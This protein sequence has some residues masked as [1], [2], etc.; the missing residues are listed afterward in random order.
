MSGMQL[1]SLTEFSSNTASTTITERLSDGLQLGSN[2]TVPVAWEKRDASILRIKLS[3]PSP[4]PSLNQLAELISVQDLV[5]SELSNWQAIS[6]DDVVVDIDL[7]SRRLKALWLQLSYDCTWDIGQLALSR[8]NRLVVRRLRTY[9]E[10]RQPL[11][12]ARSFSVGIG[13]DVQLGDGI[14]AFDGSLPALDLSVRLL[15]DSSIKVSEVAALLSLEALPDALADIRIL[16]LVLDLQATSKEASLQLT[17]G[18]P[19]RARLGTADFEVRQIALA[20]AR[21]SGITSGSISGT[22][23]LAGV[24]IELGAAAA[25]G[26]G[27]TFSGQL[28]DTASPPQLSRLVADLLPGT[29]LPPEIPDVTM[30]E[31]RV[32]FSPSTGAVDISAKA[33]SSFK[34]GQLALDVNQ[35]DFSF[36][37]TNRAT[38]ITC[39]LDF[40]GSGQISDELK[41]DSF[42]LKFDYDGAANTFKLLG[43]VSAVLF[44]QGMALSASLSVENGTRKL[45]VK[46]G[47]APPLRLGSA[48]KVGSAAAGVE[49]DNAEFKISMQAQS[50]TTWSLSADGSLYAA[51]VIRVEK[52][53]VTILRGDESGLIFTAPK[54]SEVEIPF[55]DAT[56]P[57]MFLGLSSIKLLHASGGW[58]LDTRVTCGLRGLPLR[59]DRV[60]G[61]TVKADLSVTSGSLQ[62]TLKDPFSPISFQIPKAGDRELGRI[63]FKLAA[64]T[65][66]LSKT[67]SLTLELQ[68]GL[69]KRLDFLLG[70]DANDPSQPIIQEFFATVADTGTADPPLPGEPWVRFQIGIDTNGFTGTLLSSPIQKIKLD[71]PKDPRDPNKTISQFTVN[72]DQYGELTLVVPTLS[73]RLNSGSFA[74]S[75]SVEIS[76]PLQL[77]TSQL[78]KLLTHAGLTKLADSLP[79]AIPLTELNLLDSDGKLNTNAIATFLKGIIDPVPQS[80]LDSL[81]K[82]REL[83]ARLPERF[84]SFLYFRLPNRLDYDIA[85][86]PS[87]TVKFKLQTA[88][89]SPLRLL[90]PTLGPGGIPMLVGIELRSLSFGPVLGGALLLLQADVSLDVF[91]IITLAVAASGVTEGIQGLPPTETLV[92][93]IVARE[94][95]A[96]ICPEFPVPV[97]LF[98]D[99][100]SFTY[101][102]IEGAE[103]KT[104]WKCP[105]P[106]LDLGEVVKVIDSLVKYFTKKEYYLD[107]EH[108]PEKLNLTFTSGPHYFALPSYLGGKMLGDRSKVWKFDAYRTL[109]KLLN[110]IKRPSISDI[111]ESMP[112]DL[113]LGDSSLNLGPLGFGVEWAAASLRETLGENRDPHLQFA[114]NTAMSLAPWQ[115]EDLPRLAD[116]EGVILALKGQ[117]GIQYLAG[118]AGE[119]ALCQYQIDTRRP[120]FH[121]RFRVTGDLIGG[122]LSA[123]LT[124]ELHVEEPESSVPIEGPFPGAG[125]AIAFSGRDD[126]RSDTGPAVRVEAPQLTDSFCL[127]VWLRP[128]TSTRL[129]RGI[130]GFV[131]TS[132]DLL[133]GTTLP[134]QP[135]SALAFFGDGGHVLSFSFGSAAVTY[136]LKDYAG[137]WV[138][139]TFVGR[140]NGAIALYVNG[141]QVGQATTQGPAIS[142]TSIMLGKNTVG[143][144]AG[145]MA[146]LRVYASYDTE[147]DPAIRYNPG[148]TVGDSALTGC[149]A[150]WS[151][152]GT[153][154]NWARASSTAAGVPIR[155]VA[156]SSREL[157]K[158]ATLISPVV[159]ALP[160]NENSQVQSVLRLANANAYV[161]VPSFR[162]PA[163][164]PITIEFWTYVRGDQ[165]VAGSAFSIGNQLGASRLQAHVPFSDGRIYWDC[166]DIG[167]LGGRAETDFGPY[168]DKWTHVALV[169]AGRGGNL[170]AIYLDGQL[171]ASLPCSQGTTQSLQGLTIGHEWASSTHYDQKGLYADF[172][173]WGYARSQA[174]ICRD[175]NLRISGA[176]PGLLGYWPL[177][178]FAGTAATDLSPLGNHGVLQHAEFV[179]PIAAGARRAPVLL[180][181]SQADDEQAVQVGVAR[182]VLDLTGEGGVRVQ[183]FTWPAG[184]PITVEFW[185]FVRSDQLCQGSIFS[186]GNQASPNRVQAHCPWEDG[187]LYFDYGNIDSQSGR[188]S[189]DFRPYLDQWVHVA[190]VGGGNQPDS[191]LVVYLNGER[192]GVGQTGASGAQHDLT[193]LSIGRESAGYGA[194]GQRALLAEFRIWNLARSQAEILATLRTDLKDMLPGLVGYWKLSEGAGVS[195]QDSGPR[196]YPS[197]LNATRWADAAKLGQNRFTAL[198]PAEPRHDV[199]RLD[200]NGFVDVPEWR[201]PA[202]SPITVEFWIFVR[203]DE[204]RGGSVFSMGNQ[205]SPNRVQ[206]HCPWEDGTLHWDYGD[207]SAATGRVSVDF[208]PYLSKWVHVA[209]VSDGNIASGRMSVYLNG[210]LAKQGLQGTS[211]P[212]IALQG[213]TIG[214]RSSADGTWAQRGLLSEFRIWN[215]ARSQS[216]ILG[217]MQKELIGSEAG[218]VGY[219]RFSEGTGQSAYDYGQLGYHGRLDGLAWADTDQQQHGEFVALYGAQV[220]RSKVLKL[221]GSYFIDIPDFTWRAG[222]PITVEFWVF[223]RPDDASA[224]GSIFSIGNRASPNRVQ[225]HCPWSNK[226]LY[227]DYGDIGRSTGRRAVDFTPYLGKWVHVAL[228]SGGNDRDG[229]SIIFLNG[230]PTDQGVTG[231][232]G[233]T[234]D[235][236][237]LTIGRESTTV[238]TFSQRAC[239]AEFRIWNR[240]R[241]QGEIAGTMYSELQGTEEGL[242]CYYKLSEGA[243]TKVYDHGGH[244]FHA[245]NAGILWAGVEQT[246]NQRLAL[247]AAEES[248]RSVLRLDG[249]GYVDVPEFSWTAGSP[250]TVEFWIFVRADQLCG[251]SVF[252]IGSQASPNRVQAHCPWEDGMLRWDY[253]DITSP[254]GRL[255]ADFNPHLNQWVHVA[256]VSD[257]N[258]SSGR[259]AIYINGQRSVQ[260]PQGVSGPVTTLQ[261]LTIGRW[262]GAD[263]VWA[264]RALLAEFRIWNRVRTD[265]E[266]TAWAQRRLSGS[267]DGLMGYWPLSENGSP[268][269]ADLTKRTP[270]GRLVGAQWVPHRSLGNVLLPPPAAV[271]LPAVLDTS[272]V[273]LAV[274]A[275][276]GTTGTYVDFPDFVLPAGWP[277][278]IE[279]FMYWPSDAAQGFL[280]SIGDQPAPSCVRISAEDHSLRFIFGG[281]APGIDQT[282]VDFTSRKNQWVHVAFVAGGASTRCVYING[283]LV[284]NTPRSLATQRTLRGLRLGRAGVAGNFSYG[285]ALVTEL[286]IWRNHRTADQIL[287]TSRNRLFGNEQDLWAYWPLQQSGGSQVM[288]GGSL[289]VHGWLKG[290][291]RWTTLAERKAA[292]RPSLGVPIASDTALVSRTRTTAFLLQ[293]SAVLQVFG[294][295]LFDGSLEITDRSFE[296]KI[297]M[298]LTLLGTISLDGSL[299][300]YIDEQGFEFQGS[301]AIQFLGNTVAGGSFRMTQSTGEVTGIVLGTTWCYQLYDNEARPRA[302]AEGGLDVHPNVMQLAQEGVVAELR[303]DI[304]R[305]IEQASFLAADGA[306]A[307]VAALFEPPSLSE[308]RFSADG[309]K[310]SAAGCLRKE[311][312]GAIEV[313]A[314]S[315][316]S[317]RLMGVTGTLDA[318]DGYLPAAQAALQSAAGATPADWTQAL[319]KGVQSALA[320]QAEAAQ[321]NAAAGGEV[322]ALEAR[323]AQARQQIGELEAELQLLSTYTTE[324]PGKE[325]GREIDRQRQIAQALRDGL[326]RQVS[327]DD[328]LRGHAVAQQER[329]R[330]LAVGSSEQAEALQALLVPAATAPPAASAAAETRIT[331]VR[332]DS[333]LQTLQ[334][335]IALLLVRIADPAGERSLAVPADLDDPESFGRCLAA[336]LSSST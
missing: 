184:S 221:D 70:T 113:R 112:Y 328:T 20:A 97:P 227:W 133:P 93:Q 18:T 153:S 249:S 309:A 257:G 88:P 310:W 229:R 272:P 22:L 194:F 62:L 291:A 4:L 140:K 96:I 175:M 265:S 94:L 266:L 317:R 259:L 47:F 66:T 199:L 155:R 218:L 31:L 125:W 26:Q 32:S 332:F 169:S 104:V 33:A 305:S 243:G 106:S 246:N 71:T 295:R 212:Q 5:P 193:G 315:L 213:L 254:N 108:P 142:L 166:G 65:A 239:L 171:A 14:V 42:N 89:D 52:G 13:A 154:P 235:L 245:D 86:D 144:F 205:A 264:Q 92:R 102:G 165:K 151:L 278:T 57:R 256:L 222:S 55:G 282:E 258:S 261:G 240:A 196:N 12:A 103:M 21:Q 267:E 292:G 316:A 46:S 44:G 253:G 191:A 63:W 59:L 322:T 110:G 23:A 2:L 276:D 226:W 19:W 138:H 329:A 306:Q 219:W 215:R 297:A 168:F 280:L 174:E 80:V 118:L 157:P 36:K 228:V 307:G 284:P 325:P 123:E 69:P 101:L 95:F 25:T 139:L 230:K 8:P 180:Q 190:L 67:P 176:A 234:A 61:N 121:T 39:A 85:V 29:T 302:L 131:P 1:S 158:L 186:I 250:I 181:V 183:D 195:T 178:E 323:I 251:G 185:I 283:A 82:L 268:F 54:N 269:A 116:S 128:S 170:I 208:R 321:W 146:G 45:S 197:T 202:G 160:A 281:D 299:R 162:F 148:S 49:L 300:G 187:R 236:T 141:T 252:A 270:P 137:K 225:A 60:L 35:L 289:G 3:R 303:L 98:Y 296:I 311:V 331:D 326:L 273:P 206:A 203:P 159:P 260:S 327:S 312:P 38:P 244:G 72:L 124:G 207:I 262:S 313:H 263:G 214:R 314:V 122:A 247:E 172:R 233:P 111:V 201:W 135:T 188:V 304:P 149:L 99:E 173:I 224:G 136:D 277:V 81:D 7:A 114:L 48:D 117:C 78:K 336:L 242:V 223:V 318:Q 255:L 274:L 90:V 231:P 129:G 177:C 156:S 30:K 279:F 6:I 204:L 232:S 271:V 293:G 43:G 275:L 109:A 87:G 132:S 189:V 126:G 237:G 211:G 11:D 28:S 335:G 192:K 91:D 83:S 248:R 164:S 17:L 198:L 58:S 34:L 324:L 298:H 10:I 37:R 241:V 56:G 100:L 147:L 145:Y 107:P 209:L 216:E 73:G 51:G 308:I 16:Q 182:S 294:Q 64:I 50:A 333:D 238:G 130:F 84:R 77:P 200:G 76:K 163:G 75:G 40:S 105:M 120:E 288:G 320:L 220:P 161:D 68:L 319:R 9:V 301:G 24:A 285:K 74:A 167:Q 217:T 179:S 334:G 53:N 79:N 115:D 287:G 286:R 134:T 210:V 150:S 15:P 290:S 143:A 330:K 119:F 27:W 127:A 41:F 152:D